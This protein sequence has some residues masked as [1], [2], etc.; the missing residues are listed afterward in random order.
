MRQVGIE[1]RHQR[2]RRWLTKQDK[3]APP[4]PDLLGR[5]FTAEAPDIECH[6][7]ITYIPTRESR[8]AYLAP[9]IDLFSGHPTGWSIAEHHRAELVRDALAAAV[10]A[11]G[12]DVT[13]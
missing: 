5:D 11:R 12:G 3:P 4:A 9:V 10:A 8:F 1:G 7:E 2:R 13:G 6:G